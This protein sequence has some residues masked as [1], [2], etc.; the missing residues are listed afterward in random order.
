M[1]QF[2]NFVVIFAHFKTACDQNSTCILYTYVI[3]K[4]YLVEIVEYFLLLGWERGGHLDPLL[5][6]M[7]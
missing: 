7:Y 6:C 5:L 2:L 3:M 4:S 1:N